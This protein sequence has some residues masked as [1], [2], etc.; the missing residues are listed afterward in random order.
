MPGRPRAHRSRQVKDIA[1]I[2]HARASLLAL[3]RER[4]VA[5]VV[6]TWKAGQRRRTTSPGPVHS[7]RVACALRYLAPLGRLAEVDAGYEATIVT[8]GGIRR[9]VVKERVRLRPGA[10]TEPGTGMTTV[11]SLVN[12][13]LRWTRSVA[14]WTSSTAG[15]ERR[16]HRFLA[17]CFSR[18]LRPFWLGMA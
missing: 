2:V 12:G 14:F 8:P 1:G 10:L 15:A 4:F 16:R 7:I 18:E 5:R 9:G 3:S 13:P 6:V 17:A 11:L